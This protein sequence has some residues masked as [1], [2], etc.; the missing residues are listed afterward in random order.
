VQREQI[1]DV[2]PDTGSSPIY[3]VV[4]MENVL[5]LFLATLVHYTRSPPPEH[6]NCP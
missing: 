3:N 2:N 4:N 6:H 1:Y 5:V